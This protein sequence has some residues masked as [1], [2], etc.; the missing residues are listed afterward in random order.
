MTPVV[1]VQHLQ[2]RYGDTLAADD[3]S[4]QVAKGEIFGILGPNGAGKTTAVE[5]MI[6]L[7]RPD[8]GS[9]RVLGMDPQRQRTEL[10]Q[11]IGTQLQSAA[12]ADR[13]AVWE[14]LDLFSSFYSRT[15]P[16][17]P[18]LEQW[19]LAEKRNTLYANLSGGQKQRLFIALALVND[20]EVVFL[21]ELTAGLDPQARRTTWDLVRAIRDQGK[22][23]VLVTHFM[24]E[25]EALCDRLAIIDHGRIIALDRPYALI[26]G[27]EAEGRLDFESE[28][29]LDL[30]AIQALTPVSAAVQNGHRVTVYGR[31]DSLAAAVVTYLDAARVRFQNLRTAQPNLE[32]VFLHLTGRQLRS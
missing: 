18:L 17:E 14:A 31:P 21:D 7:R 5:S 25:A 19:G 27:L 32:D 29:A 26:A 24:D 3:L 4:F 6:G 10:A 30:Q 13:M 23:V 9:I 1:D 12:L 28:Q 16:W 2:K 15:V 8:Q 22:T 20:P 11:R